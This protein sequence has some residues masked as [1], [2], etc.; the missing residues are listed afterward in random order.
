MAE[1]PAHPVAA[2]PAPATGLAQY[3]SLLGWLPAYRREWLRGD[4]IGGLTVV[5]LLVPEG[6]A[7]AQLA[8]MPPQA[9]FY[10]APVGLVLYAIFGTSRQRIVTV[11]ASVA[12]MSASTV[13]LLAAQGS[14]EATCPRLTCP[15]CCWAGLR[16]R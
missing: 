15:P 4:L 12:V 16:W 1:P 2:P 6:M 10:A 3:L 8:G 5:A 14:P 13:G 7:Y 11:S 9:A